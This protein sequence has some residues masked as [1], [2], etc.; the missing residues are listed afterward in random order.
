MLIVYKKKEYLRKQ[1]SAQPAIMP[2]TR[3]NDYGT[4]HALHER[5]ILGSLVL[6]IYSLLI[7]SFFF[8]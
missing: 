1:M 5:L 6:L 7:F 4:E 3:G 8:I 2:K